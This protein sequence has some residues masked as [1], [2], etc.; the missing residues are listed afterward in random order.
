MVTNNLESQAVAFRKALEVCRI[1]GFDFH[2]NVIPMKEN[3]KIIGYY[4]LDETNSTSVA[5]ILI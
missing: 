2:Q 5:S 4:V 3:N 1:N